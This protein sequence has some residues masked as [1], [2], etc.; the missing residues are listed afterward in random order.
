M[1]AK[2]N[3]GCEA[4]C[5]VMVSFSDY[6]RTML[7]SWSDRSRIVNN[8]SSVKK[9]PAKGVLKNKEVLI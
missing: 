1:S 4:G 2:S 8:V 7:G 6:S 5:G 9:F 3:L